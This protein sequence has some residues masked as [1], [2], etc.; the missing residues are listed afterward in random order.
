MEL[1][2]GVKMDVKGALKELSIPKSGK[3]RRVKSPA[4]PGKYQ[5]KTAHCGSPKSTPRRI[6][7]PR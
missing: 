4:N 1:R 5:M 6:H 3:E 7:Q 2:S